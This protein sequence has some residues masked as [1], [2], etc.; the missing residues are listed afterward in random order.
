MSWFHHFKSFTVVTMNCLTITEYLC[1]EWPRICSIYHNHNPV[2]SSF[3]KYYRVCSKSNA[4]SVT[5]GEPLFILR[6]HWSS[7]PGFSVHVAWSLVFCV[8]FCRLLFVLLSFSCLSLSCLSFFYL[9]LLIT[10][11]ISSNFSYFSYT[12]LY[13]NVGIRHMLVS[14]FLYIQ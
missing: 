10:Y 14:V 12:G 13:N 8:V 3:M 6:E 2:F 1:H 9:R 11:L 7:F 4:M 5:S